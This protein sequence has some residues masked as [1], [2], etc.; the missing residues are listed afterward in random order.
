L[1]SNT[2]NYLRNDLRR[3][4]LYS[5][6]PHRETAQFLM[7]SGIKRALRADTPATTFSTRE[8]EER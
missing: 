4:R 6:A 7:F 5:H 3:M 8:T 1:Q 2:G